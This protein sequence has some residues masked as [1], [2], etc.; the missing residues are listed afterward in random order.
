MTPIE[1]PYRRSGGESSSVFADLF[2]SLEPRRAR[3]VRVF[4]LTVPLRS[5]SAMW[6]AKNQ[7]THGGYDKGE[8]RS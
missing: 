5:E 1:L 2:F 7:A 3:Q 8:R 4:S 6:R